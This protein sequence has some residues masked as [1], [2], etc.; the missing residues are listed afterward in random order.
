M[1]LERLQVQEFSLKPLNCKDSNLGERPCGICKSCM[2][3]ID[4]SPF[5]VEYDAAMMGTVDRIRE[6]RDTFY[7]RF[8]RFL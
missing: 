2:Y 7:Y 3:D 8:R 4:N 6:L 1:D 5:Y